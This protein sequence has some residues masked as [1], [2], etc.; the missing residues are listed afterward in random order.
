MVSKATDDTVVEVVTVDKDVVE[1][2]EN[3]EYMEKSWK[4]S[5]EDSQEGKIQTGRQRNSKNNYTV[6]HMATSVRKDMTVYIVCGQRR[7]TTRQQRRK[8]QWEFVCYTNVSH[9]VH[10]GVGREKI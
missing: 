4:T 8:I 7:D 9:T 10:D 1:D 3:M 5:T 2:N 6:T